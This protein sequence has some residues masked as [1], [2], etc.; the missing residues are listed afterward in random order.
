MN[1]LWVETHSAN[2]MPKC[3]SQNNASVR[4]CALSDQTTHFRVSRW[5]ANLL[6]AFKVIFQQNKFSTFLITYHL[7]PFDRLPYDIR[8]VILPFR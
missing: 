4:Y 1:Y 8:F 7:T 3:Q 2:A 5:D 6:C